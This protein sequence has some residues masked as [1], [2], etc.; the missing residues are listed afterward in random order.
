M[1]RV[2]RLRGFV[3]FRKPRLFRIP[4]ET[5]GF[6]IPRGLRADINL[7]RP[8]FLPRFHKETDYFLR[9]RAPCCRRSPDFPFARFASDP[10]GK[11]GFPGNFPRSLHGSFA[12]ISFGDLHRA[13][14]PNNR[15][16]VPA[17][18]E[19]TNCALITSG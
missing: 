9:L 19:L 14:L 16:T 11:P 7:P 10:A 12:G 17:I 4:E 6:I 15:V 3:K 2:N 13:T 8:I 18:M 1:Q 5:I